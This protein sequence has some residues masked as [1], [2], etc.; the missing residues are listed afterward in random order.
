MSKRNKR[1]PRTIEV[2]PADFPVS[3]KLTSAFSK[4]LDNLSIDE[5]DLLVMTHMAHATFGHGMQAM[6][7]ITGGA[8]SAAI[9]RGEFSGEVGQHHVVATSSG[10]A[11]NVLL[12]GLGGMNEVHRPTI[13]GMY[14]MIIDEASRIGASK[15]TIPVFAGQMFQGNLRGVLAV[16]RCRIAERQR[17]GAL[18][19]VK[20]IEVLSTAQARRHILEGLKVE[21]QLCPVCHDPR[22]QIKRKP[23]G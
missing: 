22:L 2:S 21:K 19:S 9:E 10:P 16:M 20:E 7:E 11:R 6:D 18:G 23:Q 15:V 1:A 5:T 13:C 3:F 17:S 14:R 8:I 4:H 12:I